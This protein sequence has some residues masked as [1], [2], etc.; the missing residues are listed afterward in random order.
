L[1]KKTLR[2]LDLDGKRVLMR[3]D[4]NVPLDTDGDVADDT[5]IRA[6]LPSIDHIMEN[7]GSVVLMSHLG[8]PKGRRDPSLSLQVVAYYLAELVSHPVKFAG[9]CIGDEA[10][11]KAASLKKGEILLLENLR[12]YSEETENDPSFAEKLSRY[13]DLYV[14][15]AFGTAHRAH[16]S[17]AGVAKF[18]EEKAAGFLMHKELETLGGLL[19]EP[20][21]PFIAVLGGAKVSGKIGLIRNLLDRVDR[22]VIGGGMAFTFFKAVGLEIGNSL[23]DDSYLDMCRELMEAAGS[24]EEKRIFL[25]VDCVVAREIN[26]NT[27]SRTVSTGDIPEGWIGVDI[28]EGTVEV[29]RGEIM[30]ARTIFWNGPMGIFEIPAYA[31]G[32]KKISRAIVDATA[33]GAVSVV[34]GGDSVAALGQLQMKDGV[35]HISTGGGASLEMLEGKVLPGV[36]ALDEI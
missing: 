9:D 32:T 36:E 29:F 14:N 26:P 7:G 13:G 24:A 31:E 10:A 11:R 12:F 19:D 15:D 3:V 1:A 20:Q 2:D 18:F 21:R 4:F 16:A 17:T 22:I 27:E 30:K 6:V 5:R 35:T 34:G 25:P 8:R 28:G 33:A 23:L